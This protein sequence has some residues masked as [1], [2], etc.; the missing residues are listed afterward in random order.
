MTQER[1]RTTQRTLC[2]S[3]RLRRIL[4]PSFS[5]PI[6]NLSTNVALVAGSSSQWPIHLD[7]SRHQAIL[8]LLIPR[9]QWGCALSLGLPLTER[10]N[11]I[12]ERYPALVS[13]SLPSWCHHSSSDC[14]K[15]S[16]NMIR[17]VAM[18]REASFSTTYSGCMGTSS[19]G[20]KSCR[21]QG[22]R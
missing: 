4:I 20:G 18:Q 17:Q 14:Y 12:S 8:H 11:L 13:A 21:R 2:R 6:Q 5:F 15:I 3:L 22:L 16:V 9:K 1:L 10:V 7:D 19:L